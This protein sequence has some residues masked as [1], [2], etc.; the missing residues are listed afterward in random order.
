MTNAP[1]EPALH[2]ERLI[3]DYGKVHAVRDID[4]D[5]HRGEVFG[6]LGPNG[7]G[8]TTTIRC[9]LDLL[10]PGGGGRIEILGADPLRDGVAIRS[11]VAYVPG[12]L[13]LPNG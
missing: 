4:L 5:V 3:K 10:H 12:E 7:A 11:R 9:C 6:F 13:R 1:A 2:I 8:K